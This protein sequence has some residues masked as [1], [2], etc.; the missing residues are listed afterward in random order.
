MDWSDGKDW[1]I[2]IAF[3]TA[4]AAIV[5]F[6][7][8]A[9]ARVRREREDAAPEPP[10]PPEPIGDPRQA[11]AGIVIAIAGASGPVSREALRLLSAEAQKLFKL[12]PAE[13]VDLTVAGQ[14]LAGMCASPDAA[15]RR[16]SPAVR[17]WIGDHDPDWVFGLAERVALA[18]GKDLTTRQ[19]RLIRLLRRHLGEG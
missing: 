5:F 14:R 6:G 8:I 18:E 2:I 19:E 7:F 3:V 9:P 10:P 1:Q 12:P 4:V 11:V 16:L 17:A 15:V 13:A